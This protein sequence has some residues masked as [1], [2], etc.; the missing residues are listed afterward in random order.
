MRTG[1]AAFQRMQRISAILN[2]RFSGMSLA[3]IA[4]AESPPCTVQN[5]SSLIQRA[6]TAAPQQ[7]VAEIRALEAMRLDVMTEK[8]WPAVLMGDI[9]AIDRALAV[10]AR[11]AKLLGLDLQPGGWADR[12]GEEIDPSTIKVEIIGNP[13]IE[14]VRWM[15]SEIIRLRALTEG[16]P[17]TGTL[18]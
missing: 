3:D 16:M 18:N 15:E 8:L 2:K 14:R 9:A 5:I 17:S 13:E 11:R 1:K 4:A 12:D 7:G 6:L 10:M